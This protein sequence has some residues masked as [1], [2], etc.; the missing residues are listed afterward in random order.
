MFIFS[1]FLIGLLLFLSVGLGGIRPEYF[2]A[3]FDITAF[4]IVTV[5][6]LYHVLIRGQKYFVSGL[7]AVI[8]R[9][10]V[11][12]PAIADYFRRLFVW[13]LGVG[14]VGLFWGTIGGTFL[15]R[16]G[17]RIGGSIAVGVLSFFY[18]GWLALMLFRPIA[19]RFTANTETTDDFTSFRRFPLAATLF[20][21]AA[22]FLMR[23]MMALVA[24]AL[25]STN[26]A[27]FVPARDI[28]H[29]AQQTL[30][31]LNPADL[32]GENTP[33]LPFLNPAY[34]WDAPIF[35]A[36]AASFI[37]F[38]LAAGRLR[39]RYDWI[40]VCI[41]IGVLWS[42][43]GMIIMFCDLDPRLYSAGCLV[44]LLSVL[45]G[46]MA[47]LVVIVNRPY[48][49]YKLAAFAAAVSLMLVLRDFDP[50][51]P[52]YMPY[53]AILVMSP[54]AY[55]FAGEM[56]YRF[57]VCGGKRPAPLPTEPLTSDE[58]AARQVL[59]D[60]VEKERHRK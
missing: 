18:A 5:G 19:E 36:V 21:V 34:Y 10:T 59:D 1:L 30:L 9:P 41:L 24:I 7:K 31:S 23:A 53:C 46:L 54:L 49:C 48:F 15:M 17:D 32:K 35:L 3:Y 27:E 4:V 33:P 37:A 52:P 2:A 25:I 11:A 22:L 16:D 44:C 12:D 14:L 60:V 43:D 29:L 28:L 8:R 55:G 6:T 58:T 56:F 38:R 26:H 13:T 20:A 39:N 42:L 45:Y 57:L 50:D 40:P 51:K 47:A